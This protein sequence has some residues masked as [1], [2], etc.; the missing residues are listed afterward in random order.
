MRDKTK[1]DLI[2]NYIVDN[3]EIFYRVAYK[4]VKNS[5]DA[6]DIVQ[7]TTYKALMA[8]E[9]LRE[10]QYIKSWLYRI[11]VNVAVDFI[12]SN[13]KYKLIDEEKILDDEGKLDEYEDFD[14]N[15]ALER[16]PPMQKTIIILRYFEDLKIQEIAEILNENVNTTKTKLYA[17]L[18]KLR[19]HIEG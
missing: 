17:A 7:E 13:S 1:E 11:L 14:L 16:L 15:N 10:P 5:E 9:Q 12:R 4:Y 6:L 19:I 2:V 8:K 3:K 18:K